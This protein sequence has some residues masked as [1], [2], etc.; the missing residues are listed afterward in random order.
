M[1]MPPAN[2]IQKNRASDRRLEN[3]IPSPQASEY[4]RWIIRRSSNR[5][6]LEGGSTV[7]EG[8][9][10]GE[11]E[12]VQEATGLQEA[13][14]ERPRRRRRRSA[15]RSSS[16]K[17]RGRLRKLYFSLAAVWGFLAGTG[18]VLVGLSA[19]GRPAR[20]GT[21]GSMLVAGAAILALIGGVVAAAGYGSA[22]RRLR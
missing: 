12:R 15:S 3:V 7:E 22:S 2:K 4:N 5:A 17:T 1:Q 19:A 9:G 21:S 20:L 10:M 14:A 11:A 6:A 8:Q 13:A 18:A 16:R